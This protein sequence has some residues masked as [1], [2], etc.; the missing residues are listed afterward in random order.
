MAIGIAELILLGLLASWLF[1]RLRLPG[2]IGLLF[3]G[4]LFGPYALNLLNNEMQL[5]SSDL[6][7]IALIIILL[8]SGFELSI[9]TLQRVGPRALLMAFLPCL[10][11]VAAIT[12]TAPLLLPLSYLEAAMMG[13][14]IAGVSLAVI[15]PHMIEL[16]EEGLG[17]KSGVPTL[18]MAGTSSDNA[19]AIILCTSFIA[20]YVGDSVNIVWNILSVPIAAATG[21]ALGLFLGF[22]FYRIFLKFN[23]RATKR[24]LVILGAAV[25]LQSFQNEI[26]TIFPFSALLAVMAIGLY[27]L[28]QHEHMAHEISSKLGKIWIFAQVLL[29]TLI[30]T[31]VNIPIA[32]EAGLPSIAIILIGLSGRSIGVQLCMLGSTFTKKER[33]FM[34][35]AYLPKA[36]VQA[37][38]GAY[39]LLAMKAA[40]MDTAPGELI[41]AAA[42]LSIVLT[43]P[44]GSLLIRFTKNRLLEKSVNPEKYSSYEAITESR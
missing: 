18:I 7:L 20:M 6:R 3:V 39:P 23:P 38:I 21:I 19:F 43:A 28:E 42:V 25:M 44:I 1:E 24:T 9:K 10:L 40:G 8:R 27:I 41:L 11:E 36:T 22:M 15:V 16:I 37:A 31:E 14:V 34:T 26:N 5:I 2:L 13:S 12:L 32:V 35:I 29:F 30:G 4:I 17:I 33:L